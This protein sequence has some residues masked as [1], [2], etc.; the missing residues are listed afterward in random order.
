LK[1]TLLSLAASAAA[2]TAHA[3]PITPEAA[4]AAIEAS[5]A[6]ISDENAVGSDVYVI[7]A[8]WA[9][10]NMNF[11]VR[12]GACTEAGSCSWVMTFATFQISP[13][14]WEGLLQKANAYNDSY[15]F[16]RAFVLPDDNGAPMAVGIDYVVNI[17]DEA[18]FDGND[19]EMFRTIVTSFIDHWTEE[20]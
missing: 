17:A 16:G 1:Y 15:P 6:I 5:G 3:A 11:S 9:D 4:K 10:T 13:E 2:F 20:S 19:L 14:G 8:S 12:L 7:D 18:T